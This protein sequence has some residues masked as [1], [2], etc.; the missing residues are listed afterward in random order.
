MIML[1]TCFILKIQYIVYEVFNKYL[2]V[3]KYI[4]YAYAVHYFVKE[5]ELSTLSIRSVRHRVEDL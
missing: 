4:D 5:L 1:M 2:N 3:S